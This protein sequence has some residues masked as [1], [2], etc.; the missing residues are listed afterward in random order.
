[1]RPGLRWQGL[2]SL[3]PFL[4]LLLSVSFISFLLESYRERKGQRERKSGN[5]PF[6][7]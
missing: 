5:L 1:M 2:T 4:T 6:A 7:G 3:E